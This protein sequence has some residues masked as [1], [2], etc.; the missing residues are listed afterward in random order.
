MSDESRDGRD[1]V[2]T[3]W[4]V[5][6]RREEEAA[7]RSIR[8]NQSI[9]SDHRSRRSAGNKTVVS[10][11]VKSGLKGLLDQKP[12]QSDGDGVHDFTSFNPAKDRA[13]IEAV[14]AEIEKLEGQI[15]KLIEPSEAGSEGSEI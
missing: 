8:L 6:R 4:K 15:E 13:K 9:E 1:R 7:N 12:G 2:P 5:A 14:K 3:R 10:L 11:S